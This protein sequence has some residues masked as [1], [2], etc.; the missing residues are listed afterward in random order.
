M[1]EITLRATFD[2]VEK[3]TDFINNE[4][5]QLNCPI[6]I[7]MLIDIVIDEVFSNIVRYAY[8]PDTGDATVRFDAEENPLRVVMTFI[9]SGKPFNPLDTDDPDVTLPASERKEGGLGIFIVKK[10]M[11]SVTYSYRD[12]QNILTIRK[13]LV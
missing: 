8:S 13:I 10:T 3:V 7:Q 6:N 1:K 4:L 11:D 5:E 12:G 2:N 9:D